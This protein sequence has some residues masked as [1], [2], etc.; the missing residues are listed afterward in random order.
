MIIT[1]EGEKFDVEF[2][3]QAEQ[4]QTLE[5]EGIPFLIELESVTFHGQS[6]ELL[7]L[8]SDDVV[9]ELEALVF[10]KLAEL[11]F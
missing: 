7:G 10:A 5:Q 8:M 1:Y 9:E 4:K 11:A 3:V 2:G 6:K